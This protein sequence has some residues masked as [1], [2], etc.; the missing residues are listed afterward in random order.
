MEGRCARAIGA[1]LKHARHR[2]DAV[3]SQL[4]S[5]SPLAVLGRGYSLTRRTAD[6]SVARNAAELTP[7]EQITTRLARGEVVSRVERTA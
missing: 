2:T 6:G 7:G 3:A 4:E 1:H 5:L